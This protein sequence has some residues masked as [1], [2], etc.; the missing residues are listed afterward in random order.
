MVFTLHRYILRELCRAFLMTSIALTLMVSAGMLAPTIMEYG[1]SPSQMLRL[2]GYLLPI[3]LTFIL[4]IAALFAGTIVYGRFAADRELDACRASGVSL[5]VLLYPGISVAVLVAVVNLMLS[6]Y[7]TPTFFQRSEESVKANV[8]QILF[9]NIQRRGYY[10]LP[11][12]RYRL[13]AEKAFPEHNLLEGVVIAEVRPDASHR[14]VTAQRVRI[15]IDTQHTYNTAIIVAEEAYRFDEYSPVY[16]GRLEVQEQFPPLLGESIKFKQIEEIKRIEADK[17]NYFPVRERAAEARA[18]LAIELLAEKLND[19]FQSGQAVTLVDADGSRLYALSAGGCEIDTRQRLTLNLHEPIHLRQ[20]DRFR[21]GLTVDYTSPAGFIALQNEGDSLRL[22]LMLDT[23]RWQRTGGM[24]GT[25]PRKFVNDVLYPDALSDR[26]ETDDLLGLL[27]QAAQPGRI[28]DG[29]PSEQYLRRITALRQYLAV[30]DR[31]IA[32]EIHFRLVYGLGAVI[33]IMTG[34]ALGI[35]FRGGH[36]L[37]AF[38]VSAIPA[39]VFS[40]FI[41]SG[42]QMI[43]SPTTPQLVGIAATWAGLLLI[44]ILMVM[45]YRKLMRT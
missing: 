18:Q 32:A 22:E 11:Q 23:P 20:R 33:I 35:H 6:F 16:L 29:P 37:T 40:V 12:S 13:Y 5:S 45:I 24:S 2:S 28:L 31:H 30:I 10:A 25:T 7:V 14:V 36:I 17:M 27:E 4:P 42:K 21:E 3:S 43:K 41:M 1:V 15:S 19:A 39:G 38:G 44:G 34:I 9:R 26:L 8:E